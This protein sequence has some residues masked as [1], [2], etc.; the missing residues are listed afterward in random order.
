MP[1]MHASTWQ[2][3][4][5]SAA[6]AAIASIGSITPCGYCGAEPTTSTVLSLIGVG[7]RVGVGAVVA[8]DGHAH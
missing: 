5:R 4:S 3:M 2:L 7:H 6:T 8:A 1:P